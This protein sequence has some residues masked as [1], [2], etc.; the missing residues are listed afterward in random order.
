MRQVGRIDTGEALFLR[1]VDIRDL[2]LDTIVEIEKGK[3]LLYTEPSTSPPATGQRASHSGGAPDA[4]GS[5]GGQ[6]LRSRGRQVSGMAAAPGAAADPAQP[7]LKA[8]LV[9]PARGEGL[10]VPAMLTFRRMVVKQKD[11]AAA[12]ARCSACGLCF[13]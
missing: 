3:I 9:K 2:D 13:Y 1:P 4:A 12:V 7:A 8:A 10:N 5:N 11:D 6:S